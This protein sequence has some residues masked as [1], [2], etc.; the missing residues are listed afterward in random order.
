M[1]QNTDYHRFGNKKLKLLQGGN[2]TIPGDIV[3]ER[4]DHVLPV[5]LDYVV[6]TTGM[7]VTYCIGYLVLRYLRYPTTEYNSST[8][9]WNCLTPKPA[10]CVKKF[11][12]QKVA[13]KNQLKPVRR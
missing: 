3:L 7:L 4:T 8:K 9:G 12:D 6:M 10:Q 2:V 1:F 11:F 5:W 13:E